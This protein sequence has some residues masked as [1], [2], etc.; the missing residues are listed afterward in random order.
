MR[1]LDADTLGWT[2]AEYRWLM[3]FP[4]RTIG[5]YLLSE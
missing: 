1:M 3:N 4:S 2:Q 5:Y